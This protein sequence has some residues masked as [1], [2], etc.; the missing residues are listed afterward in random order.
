MTNPIVDPL[1]E[2]VDTDAAS[3]LVRL[4]ASGEGVA[5]VTINRPDKKNAFDAALIRALSETFETLQGAEHVRVV[6]VRGA[7][8]TFSAGADL[9]W[10]RD[11]IDYSES[12]NRDDAMAMAQMLKNLWDV[13]ALTVALVE[14]G[15][16]G[17]GAGLVAACDMAIAK[18]DAKFAFSEVKLGIVAA[19]ISPYVVAA[20][21][22]R[23]ARGLFATG[24]VF[25]AAHAEKIGLVTEVVADEAALEAAM[26]QLIDG[27]LACG[28]VAVAESKRIVDRVTHERIDRGV[29]EET[30]RTIARVRVSEEGQEGVR[31]FLEKRE[32]RWAE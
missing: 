28:P 5:V 27:M 24:R 1:V 6:F 13:P 31:A 14:G 30:A 12:D 8:G 11:A 7:G 9:A 15:A 18:A 32:P 23:T 19:T 16:F 21:G 20:V 4:E 26:E 3:K 17:G 10:M 25:D 22:P 2:G 29:M